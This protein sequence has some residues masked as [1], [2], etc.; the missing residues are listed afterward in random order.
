MGV[1]VRSM[2]SYGYP[3]YIR[4]NA[5]LPEE[6]A[7][8]IAA[9]KTI[10]QSSAASG[11]IKKKSLLI[12]ID[13]PA[14]AGK[15]TIGKMLADRLDYKYIDT[16]VVSNSITFPGSIF[17]HNGEIWYISIM[18]MNGPL[19]KA[20]AAGNMEGDGSGFLYYFDFYRG[21]H[22]SNIIVGSGI[23]D[24]LTKSSQER[25]NEQVVKER[26]RKNIENK[27]LGNQSH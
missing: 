8:F 2:K 17:T 14:G 26:I 5:G 1:I 19:P 6:N 20:G 22:F 13:G 23:D 11:K 24:I 16:S 21:G 7:R 15:T 18:P 25:P 3:E 10:M 27:I 9:L 4:I 12:T